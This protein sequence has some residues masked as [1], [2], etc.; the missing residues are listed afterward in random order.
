MPVYPSLT[1]ID[2]SEGRRVWEER[3]EV[4]KREWE[5]RRDREERERVERWL[6][7]W[8]EELHVEREL[9]RE[10]EAELRAQKWKHFEVC[11]S[12]IG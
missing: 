9:L 6:G 3:M 2:T 1:D 11:N 4:E 5:E 7:G 12:S 10:K 8:E